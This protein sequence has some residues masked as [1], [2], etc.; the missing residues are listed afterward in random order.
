[1]IFHPAFL[2]RRQRSVSSQYRKKRSSN[3]PTVSKAALLTTMHAPDT[4]STST[5]WLL[6]LRQ[7]RIFE[8]VMELL[9]YNLVIGEFRPNKDVSGVG[10]LLADP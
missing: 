1:M 7:V 3:P 10:K 6:K 5:G 9:G 4:Q 2:I 8:R